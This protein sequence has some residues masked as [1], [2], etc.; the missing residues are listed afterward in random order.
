M[1]LPVART[2]SD[3]E[4]LEAIRT[5]VSPLECSINTQDDYGAK[6]TFVV[7]LPNGKKLPFQ[8][9]PNTSRADTASQL[10]VILTETRRR[11]E[12]M[13]FSLNNWTQLDH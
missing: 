12:D 8:P 4:I 2:L 11:I 5:A 1:N 6:V 7:H 13:G 9:G 3:D 10:N